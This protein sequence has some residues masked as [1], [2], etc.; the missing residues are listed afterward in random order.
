[1]CGGGSWFAVYI[2]PVDVVVVVGLRGSER[3]E[4]WPVGV[5]AAGWLVAHVSISGWWVG[6][7]RGNTPFIRL[8][9]ESCPIQRNITIYANTYKVS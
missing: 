1:M 3:S 6:V 2:E 5:G 7:W 4:L 9:E 8:M